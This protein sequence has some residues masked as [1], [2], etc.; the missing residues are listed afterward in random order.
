MAAPRQARVGGATVTMHEGEKASEALVRQAAQPVDVTDAAGHT[1]RLR[2]PG[3][4]AQFRLVEALGTAAQNQVYMGMVLP[5]LFVAAI[6]GQP[7]AE[8]GSKGE[9]E[10]L[11]VRLDED[12]VQAVM[13]GVQEHFAAPDEAA[14]KNG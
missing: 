14:A 3:V 2:K 12:G 6:D 4:L 8:P 5:L 9:I 10:A 1:I 11:I 7:V 13:L